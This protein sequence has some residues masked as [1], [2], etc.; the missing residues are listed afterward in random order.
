MEE[1]R[2]SDQGRNKDIGRNERAMGSIDG[3][4]GTNIDMF[5][6]LVANSNNGDNDQKGIKD[7]K[8]KEDKVEKDKGAAGSQ[9]DRNSTTTSATATGR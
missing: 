7:K 8:D 3:D 5:K 6:S 2:Q 4:Q 1:Q 9:N